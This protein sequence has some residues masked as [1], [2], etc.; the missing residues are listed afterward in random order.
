MDSGPDA[1]LALSHANYADTDV[2][3]T[4]DFFKSF[5][6]KGFEELSDLNFTKRSTRL[7]VC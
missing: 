1:H 5:H 3:R 6:S 2:E 4:G 7:P